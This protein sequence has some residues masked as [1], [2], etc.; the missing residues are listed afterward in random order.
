MLGPA[1]VV[2]LRLAACLISLGLC[3]GCTDLRLRPYRD[4]R[5]LAEYRYALGEQRLDV[6]GLDF[7]YQ[8]L[9]Q[10][11]TVL[12]LPGL[13][14][15]IDFW[16]LNAPVLAKQYHVLLIDLPGLGKSSK[17]DASY[18]LLWVCDRI[19]AFLDAKGVERTS[20]IGGSLGAPSFTR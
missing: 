18:D 10:G 16:Q 19:I 12:I 4:D 3:A 9:G 1:E 20:V 17:P 2:V 13:G 11:P 14:T 8:E 7:C 5:C 6:G 15:N